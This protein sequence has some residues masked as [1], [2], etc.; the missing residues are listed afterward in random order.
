MKPASR[1]STARVIRV[2][3]LTLLTGVMFAQTTNKTPGKG[4]ASIQT[5][6]DE[7]KD[8]LKH[9]QTALA[10]VRGLPEIATTVRGDSQVVLASRNTVD[11][12]R[13]KVDLEGAVVPSEFEGLLDSADGCA[14]NAALSASV[15]AA[16]A[17]RTGSERKLQATMDL[18][19]PRNNFE[20]LPTTS[21]GLLNLIYNQRNLP[22][23][24]E[25][26][27]MLASKQS[28]HNYGAVGRF[29]R[30]QRY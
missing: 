25:L 1:P 8:A 27:L 13:G 11:W 4:T 16:G 6:L 2:L 15:L 30:N 28:D 20:V 19:P 17:A 24:R 26:V 10:S 22:V 23:S 21:G 14:A 9:Y 12:L 18:L 3:A 29:L 7:A 5:A